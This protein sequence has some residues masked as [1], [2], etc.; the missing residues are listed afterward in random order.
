MTTSHFRSVLNELE[1][2]GTAQNRKVYARHG[3]EEEMFGVSFAVLRK[4]GKRL[5]PD[6]EL[7]AELWATGNHDARVLA[8]M[9]DDPDTVVKTD[10][11]KRAEELGNYI[12]V[13]EFAA[14]VAKTPFAAEFARRWKASRSEWLGALSWTLVAHLALTPPSDGQTSKEKGAGSTG[15]KPARN[16]YTSAPPADDA[17][18]EQLLEII[19]ADIHKRSNRMRHSMNGALIAIGCRNKPLRRKA[20]AASKRIGKVEVDHGETNCVTPDAI[21]YIARTWQHKERMAARRGENLC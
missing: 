21:D 12:I 16:K 8:C 9:V 3:V 13:D 19:E 7:A 11:V 5:R 4:M 6:S 15:R 1:E 14:L 17:R 10:L 18:F 2:A 20:E